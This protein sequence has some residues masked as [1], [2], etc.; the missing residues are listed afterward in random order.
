MVRTRLSGQVGVLCAV[1]GSKIRCYGPADGVACSN[2][3]DDLAL[4]RQGNHWI[5][6]S[7]ALCRWKPGSSSTYLQKDL[8]TTAGLVGVSAIATEDNGVVWVGTPRAGK[9]FGLR[10]L[11]EGVSKR[12]TVPGLDGAALAVTSLFL[13]RADALWIGTVNQGIYRVYHGQADRFRSSDGL[14]SDAVQY[15]YQ[16]REGDVWVVTSKGIDCFRELRATTF[17]L[18]EGLTADGVGS[19]LATQD[20]EVWIGNQGGMDILRRGS[21]AK[22]TSRDG[23]PGQD[24]TSLLEDTT[25]RLWMGVD[26]DLAV[27]S[28]KQFRLI[29]KADGSAAGVI[30][31]LAE[32]AHHDVWASF[33]GS[34]DKPAGLLRIRNFKVIE[35]LSFPP[36]EGAMAMA[37]DHETGLW[38]GLRKGG[39]ER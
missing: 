24:I 30:I 1:E 22:M 12:Y 10:Q 32:D 33:T 19:V 37:P 36:G 21:L 35:S 3:A 17:S 6:G 4:D 25:G 26:R 31:A 38:L 20:G 34:M 27:Y 39:L 5:G 7:D 23:L 28:H 2:G 14:S 15:F 13:D 18:R 29:K 8:K 9:T 16:D 11:V